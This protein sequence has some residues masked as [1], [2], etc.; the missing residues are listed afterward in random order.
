MDAAPGSGSSPRAGAS[1]TNSN[2]TPTRT[3]S[4]TSANADF[5][6]FV[7]F[8]GLDADMRDLGEVANDLAGLGR[9]L[10][11]IAGGAGT[12]AIEK[13]L[14]PQTQRI[15]AFAERRFVIGQQRLEIGV[16]ADQRAHHG[17]VDVLQHRALQRRVVGR[18]V[19]KDL[20]Q[21]FDEAVIARTAQRAGQGS[22]RFGGLRQRA[23]LPEHAF[24]LI[25][26]GGQHGGIMIARRERHNGN[27]R[28]RGGVRELT[29]AGQ[30]RCPI[31][32]RHERQQQQTPASTRKS[33]C[34]NAASKNFSSPSTLSRKR[35]A[36]CASAR[37]RSPPNAPRSRSATTRCAPASRP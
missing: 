27:R 8:V 15:R 37:N 12:E 14:A 21:P 7:L 33:R 13:A 4:T 6:L 22:M 34:S 20:A 18:I 29:F 17:V 30:R 32:R 5:V 35:T 23:R 25:V 2:C 3:N 11:R 16:V 1:S 9:H 36:R 26:S 31:V 28:R 24:E 19:G 10:A